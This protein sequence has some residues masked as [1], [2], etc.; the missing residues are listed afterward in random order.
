MELN[1]SKMDTTKDFRNDLMKRREVEVVLDSGSNPGFSNAEKAVSENFKAKEGSVVV[2]SV[3]GKFGRNDFIVE[4]FVY[5]SKEDKDSIEP[6]KKQKKK[7]AG[8]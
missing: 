4:A 5:D 3:R 1:S 8:K 2:K 6:K 7:E